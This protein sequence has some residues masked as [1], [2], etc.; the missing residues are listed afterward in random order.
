MLRFDDDDVKPHG[1]LWTPILVNDAIVV[2]LTVPS[3]DRAKVLLEISS[4]GRGYRHFPL[5]DVEKAGSCNIDVVCPEGDPCATRSTV[6]ASIPPA[7]RP[8]APVP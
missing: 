1:E 3:V 2:E 5:T 7:A 6:W 8:S 4:I